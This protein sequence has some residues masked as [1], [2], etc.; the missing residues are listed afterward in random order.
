MKQLPRDLYR[1]ICAS[2]LATTLSACGGG[3]GGGGGDDTP[4]ASSN[5]PPD[6]NILSV[7]GDDTG[8]FGTE[9][10][11]KSTI[12]VEQSVGPDILSSGPGLVEL[13]LKPEQFG[14]FI[15]NINDDSIEEEFWVS[16]VIYNELIPTGTQIDGEDQYTYAEEYYY[17]CGESEDYIAEG[18]CENIDYDV[19]SSSVTFDN[20]IL[21]IHTQDNPGENFATGTIILNGTISWAD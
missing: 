17:S 7:S 12:F 11:Q 5:N 18:V 21:Y 8:S 2:I 14:L 3:G 1:I 16:I 9:F 13:A 20:T 15:V 4:P 19:A 10:S 6:E